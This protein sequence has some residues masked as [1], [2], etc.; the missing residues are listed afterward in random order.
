MDDLIAFMHTQLD[1]AEQ[2]ERSRCP[3]CGGPAVDVIITGM[4]TADAEVEFRPCGDFIDGAELFKQYGQDAAPFVLADIDAKRRR[5][6]LLA[7]AI[8][9]GH[10]DYDLAAE[11]LPLEALPY[12][13]RPGYKDEWRPEAQ[14]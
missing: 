8:R 6:D 13:G 7:D 12:A 2:R 10:D 11:L 9:R 5:L 4:G 3:K 14:Q 1:N